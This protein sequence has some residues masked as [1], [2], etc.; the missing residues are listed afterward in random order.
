M[1]L[2]R[3]NGFTLIELMVVVAILGILASIALPSYDGYVRRGH[4]AAA[5][6]EMMNIAN[7]QQ[8][9]FMANRQYASSVA[10]M[11]YTIPTEVTTRYTPTLTVDNAGTPPNFTIDFAATGSQSAD[12]DLSLTSAGVKMPADKWK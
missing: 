12:G 8:Q 7:L 2:R 5:Q 10:A 6:S 4:R 11:S 3:Q 1:K 9:F